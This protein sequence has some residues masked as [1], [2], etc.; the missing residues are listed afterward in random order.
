MR[1]LPHE[2]RLP[3]TQPETKAALEFWCMWLGL[4]VPGGFLFYLLAGGFP[5]LGVLSFPSPCSFSIHITVYVLCNLSISL[6]RAMGRRPAEDSLVVRGDGDLNGTGS[7]VRPA[8]VPR[9]C[10]IVRQRGWRYIC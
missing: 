8:W 3:R 9:A 2:K 5:S 7:H 10:S 6:M 4:M 1:R